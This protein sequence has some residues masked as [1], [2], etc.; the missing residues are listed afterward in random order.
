MLHDIKWA[1]GS[2]DAMETAT[3]P[4]A[5]EKN[6]KDFLAYLERFWEKVRKCGTT[7]WTAT[8]SHT[9]YRRRKDPLLLHLKHARNSNEHKLLPILE[10]IEGS[11]GG[12][13]M[14]TAG[15]GGGVIFRGAIEGG[16]PPTD[17]IWSGVLTF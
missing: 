5:Y 6:L 4:L 15:E 1:L 14:I 2:V 17:L 8:V 11:N 10:K 9:G 3:C 12:G 16:K 13:S 7:K